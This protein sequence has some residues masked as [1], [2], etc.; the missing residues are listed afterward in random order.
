MPLLSRSMSAR[1]W[2]VIP[3]YD[4]VTTLDRI[5]TATHSELAKL[6][7]GGC[8]ILVVDDNSPDGTGEL[9][10][11]LAAQ[12]DTVSVLHR[13]GKDGLGNA[14]LAGFAH[15]LSH[16]AELICEM[17]ADYS[18]DPAY[19]KDLIAAADHADLV[20]GSRYVRGGGTR[21]W[22]LLRRLISR[23]G[24][25]YARAILGVGIR[26][27]TGGFKCIHRRVLEGIDLS[28]VRAESPTARSSPATR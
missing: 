5:I 13:P 21:N 25:I 17:D 26:D 14:Y 22:G 11:R 20:L 23:G 24:G 3:T 7:V 9:A 15:A 8:H 16:G 1:I 6:E 18:H 2:I 4:E 19:L 12:Y 10:D 28:T 27:L